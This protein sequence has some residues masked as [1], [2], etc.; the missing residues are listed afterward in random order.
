MFT[1][2]KVGPDGNATLNLTITAN[3]GNGGVGSDSVIVHVIGASAY[4]IA[5][6]SCGPII[7]SHEGGS[8]TLTAFVDNPSND[9]LTYQWEQ[10]SGAPIKISS[11]TDLAPTVSL[12]AGSG[13]NVYSFQLT[14]S[15]GGTVIGNCEQYVYA[16]YPEP[17]APPVADAGPYTVV[18]GGDQVTL[19]G[20][21]STGGYLKFSWIQ[22]AGEPVQLL[23]ANTAKPIFTAPD[24]A[25]GQTKE[26]IFTNTVKNSFGKDSAMVHIMAVHPS[27]PPTAV[28]ILK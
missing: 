4:K 7:R 14:A 21:K 19:D 26:L 23:S 1:A 17:G 6:L 24:V 15:Q 8:T 28:I 18:N 5:T 27:L 16:A 11:A 10:I 12:P 3:D 13:G 20:T 25:L 2:P 9:T 22:V